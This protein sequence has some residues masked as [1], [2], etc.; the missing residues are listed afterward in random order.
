M[1]ILNRSQQEFKCS[2]YPGLANDSVAHLSGLPLGT[3]HLRSGSEWSP[4]DR[5]ELFKL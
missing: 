2:G 1:V 3:C 5:A 4:V